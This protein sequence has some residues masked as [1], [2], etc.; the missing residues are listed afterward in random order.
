[1]LFG[2]C[3]RMSEDVL[4]ECGDRRRTRRE[5]GFGVKVKVIG[6]AHRFEGK[7]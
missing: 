1:M 3:T 4:S 7:C 5:V 6:G 2:E